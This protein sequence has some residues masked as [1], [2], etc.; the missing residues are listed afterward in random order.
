MKLTKYLLLNNKYLRTRPK[1]PLRDQTILKTQM[2][3]V[4]ML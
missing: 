2:Y 1:Y 4:A 3:G